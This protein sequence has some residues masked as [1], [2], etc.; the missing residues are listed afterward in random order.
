MQKGVKIK[1]YFDKNFIENL[2]LQLQDA[3]AA[4]DA[5]LFV[6]DA[7][8]AQDSAFR[9]KTDGNSDGNRQTY[10]PLPDGAD[11]YVKNV[12]RTVALFRGNVFNGLRYAPFGKYVEIFAP[13]FPQ[14]FDETGKFRR[15]C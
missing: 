5:S 9:R 4:I 7:L 3:G 10:T 12:Q 2:A 11:G 6:K 15:T 1:D 8:S 13:R 14:Y